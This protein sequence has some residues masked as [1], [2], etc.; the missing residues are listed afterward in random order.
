MLT[1]KLQNYISQNEVVYQAYDELVKVSN[2]K[3][4]ENKDSLLRAFDTNPIIQIFKKNDQFISEDF[5]DLND[6][7]CEDDFLYFLSPIGILICITKKE[8][9]ANG[10]IE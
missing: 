1:R 5:Q 4:K 8:A 7:S 3:E 2:D 9:E 10:L 6:W